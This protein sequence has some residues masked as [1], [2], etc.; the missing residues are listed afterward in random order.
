MDRAPGTPID[1]TDGNGT[2]AEEPE[3]VS[4]AARQDLEGQLEVLHP[5]S[6]GWALACCDFDR[7]EAQEVLQ[8][9]YLKALD[10]RASFGG[11]A[12]LK[13]WFF[14][15]VRTTAREH[16]RY[17]TVRRSALM[18]WF[19]GRP[20]PA[21]VPTPE[22]L[23]AAAR[24]QAELHRL[25]ARLS[26]RQRDLLHLVFYQELTIEE[27]AGVMGITVGTARTHYERGKARLR[28]LLSGA[29]EAKWTS[30]TVTTNR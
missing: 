27:A 6:F 17:R 1:E 28:S 20:R 14:G 19:R 15:V 30:Q 3:A 23:S 25:L 12:A 24:T 7:D 9:S 2:P 16:R 5:D 18:N 26:A 4:Q 8:A 21:P 29:E 22:Y 10:G 13:T 11:R